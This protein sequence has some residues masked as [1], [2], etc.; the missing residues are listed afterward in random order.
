[1]AVVRGVL[2]L[3]GG[4]GDMDWKQVNIVA[5]VLGSPPQ[6]KF[7]DTEEYYKLVCPQLLEKTYQPLVV[8]SLLVLQSSCK[9]SKAPRWFVNRVGSLLSSR[10]CAEGGVMAVVRGVLDLGGGVGDM[11]WKQVNIVAEVLG[12]PPQEK[13]SDTE[14]Y[15]KLVCPQLLEM[16]AS[17]ESVAGVK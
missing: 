9:A 14:E 10:L 2:D 16:L 3:G 17:E 7:S 12:S 1:M 6:G 5:E 4:V 11:D 15:Y 8:R 13:F